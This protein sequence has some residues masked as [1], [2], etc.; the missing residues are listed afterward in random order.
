VNQRLIGCEV[1]TLLLRG[2]TVLGPD[3][4]WESDDH[5]GVALTVKVGEA[6]HEVHAEMV[7]DGTGCGD[8]SY[9]CQTMEIA[10]GSAL[11]EWLGAQVDAIWAAATA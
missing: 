2:E 5:L 10:N 4:I 8:T 1:S 3:D 11:H 7:V 6:H 9:S